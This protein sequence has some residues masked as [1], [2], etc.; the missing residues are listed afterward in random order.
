M[1]PQEII[2]IKKQISVLGN[3]VQDLGKII[4][5]LK[6]DRQ[7]VLSANSPIAPGAACRVS[8]DSRGLILKG[9]ELR[10]EDI[11]DLPIQKITGLEKIIANEVRSRDTN[12]QQPVVVRTK[13]KPGTG[14]KINYDEDGFVVSS[15]DLMESDI[16]VLSISKIVGLDDKLEFMKSQIENIS[17]EEM[18]EKT[19]T[20]GTFPKIT[21]G[22]DGRVI[23]GAKLTMDDIP[24]DLIT[25]MT[26]LE[27]R[28]PLLAAQQTVEALAR[29]VN[30]KVNSNGGIAP[31]VYTKVSVDEQ[32]LVLSGESLTIRDL[33]EIQMKDVTGLERTLRGKAEQSDLVELI[34]TVSSMTT[35]NGSAEIN[36]IKN[37]LATKASDEAVR[38]AANRVDT[39]Q[40]LMDTLVQKLPSDLIVDQLN[41]I[42]KDISSLSGR[43]SALEQQSK[44]EV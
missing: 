25:R 2:D 36:W 18:V 43:V 8:Y 27:N 12:S 40:R 15:A 23:S 9:E 13:I 16:P 30:G 26:T 1:N 21:F 7:L 5:A 35:N 10:I 11:P 31:G 44:I 42:Q 22:P 33:P 34:N 14:T 29:D 6:I 37:Q 17:K 38:E 3:S 19:I 41:Q 28:I 20:P 32:G 39:I 4:S 24:M